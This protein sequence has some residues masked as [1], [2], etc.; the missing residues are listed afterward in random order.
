LSFGKFFRFKLTESS[1]KLHPRITR[2]HGEDRTWTDL[3]E[4]PFDAQ[5][6][7]NLA[8][9]SKGR[10][11]IEIFFYVISWYNRIMLFFFVVLLKMG[12]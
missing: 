3:E 9:S 5:T 1:G 6:E 4:I 11:F 10:F 2:V 12:F 7:R 8:Q